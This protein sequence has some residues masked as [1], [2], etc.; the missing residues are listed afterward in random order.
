MFL[1]IYVLKSLESL[2]LQGHS[3]H[4]EP[5]RAQRKHDKAGL[6]HFYISRFYTK[7]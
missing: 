5:R 3:E 4:G 1:C 6:N 2:L 7:F